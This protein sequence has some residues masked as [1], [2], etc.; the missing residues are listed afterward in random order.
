MNDQEEAI[1]EGHQD[2]SAIRDALT[3]VERDSESKEEEEDVA[4][5]TSRS[6]Q[7][8]SNSAGSA[9]AQQDQS[10]IRLTRARTR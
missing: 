10:G 9:R 5:L 7:R 2:E 8:N 6:T 1:E 3:L 4:M